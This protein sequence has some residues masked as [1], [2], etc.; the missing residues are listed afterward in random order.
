LKAPRVP[1]RRGASDPSPHPA[2]GCRRG[3]RALQ[4]RVGF[5]FEDNSWRPWQIKWNWIRSNQVVPVPRQKSVDRG[6]GFEIQA[7]NT[8]GPS[9][10]NLEFVT[11]P[12]EE[13]TAGLGQARTAL[14]AIQQIYT[15]SL[16]PY[17]TTRRGPSASD[18]RG[19]PPHAY[20]PADYVTPAEHGF[21][22]GTVRGADVALSASARTPA[23]GSLKM[24]ATFGVGLADLP[25][26]MEYFG[27]PVPG[28]TATQTQDRDPARAALTFAPARSRILPTLGGVPAL[29]REV[30]RRFDARY[31]WM[32]EPEDGGPTVLDELIGFV[33]AVL[34]TI[35][36]LQNTDVASEEIKARLALM[37]R[38]SFVQLFSALTPDQRNAVRQNWD[39]LLSTM[40][41]VSNATPLVYNHDQA[42][43][44]WLPSDVNL[45]RDTPLIRPAKDATTGPLHR[46]LGWL[47]IERW[48]QNVVVNGTDYLLPSAQSW[49]YSWA[50][51]TARATAQDVLLSMGSVPQLDAPQFRGGP[52][53]GVFENRFIS[54]RR[55]G[56]EIPFPEAYRIA[57]NQ[58]V[59][60][61]RVRD[62]R[63]G[64]RAD[65]GPYPALTAGTMPP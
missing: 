37:A 25:T 28:E 7:D 15:N 26:V 34:Y 60:Y 18:R 47:T 64:V 5:E 2:I 65:I 23:D 21:T 50:T 43:D 44:S 13:T 52:Q 56:A 3:N 48:F 53:L 22:G 35:K 63:A 8:P 59:F 33:A 38:T 31:H 24:Q 20:I 12:F 9:H 51:W 57:W 27:T 6:P 39:A 58:L 36:A 41:D 11:Q 45:R 40:L 19:L 17:R 29:A 42:T 30:V 14:D 62:V 1:V 32:L 10:S 55:L 49:A 16:N 54:P 4:R 46:T 61:K